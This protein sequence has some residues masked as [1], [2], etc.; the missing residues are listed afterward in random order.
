[1]IKN[2]NTTIEFNQLEGSFA[3]PPKPR[4]SSKFFPKWFKDLPPDTKE[5][6]PTMKR[7]QPVLDAVSEGYIIPSWFDM[8]VVVGNCAAGLNADNQIIQPHGLPY[9]YENNAQELIGRTLDGQV[10]AEV[11]DLGFTWFIKAAPIYRGHEDGEVFGSHPIE[12]FKG[13][14]AFLSHGHAL[15]LNNLWSIKTPKGWSC[16]FRNIPNFANDY[17]NLIF[18]EA[19]VDTDTYQGA[20]NL[21]FFLKDNVAAG[22]YLIPK[23]TPLLQV[24]PYKRGELTKASFGLFTREQQHNIASKLATHFNDSYKKLFWHK[25]KQ[26]TL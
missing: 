21:P 19:N 14:T 13:M 22:E 17:H 23:G 2:N 18:A 20:V 26:E 8:K 16:R 1:M 5:Y 3:D 4:R 10:V 24:I 12:Q 9:T 15:K 25:R 11:A 6:S 7:C